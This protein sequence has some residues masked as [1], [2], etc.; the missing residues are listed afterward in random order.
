MKHV[1]TI[2][3]GKFNT[4]G[5]PTIS[6]T[7]AQENVEPSIISGCQTSVSGH[8]AVIY[9]PVF[10][11]NLTYPSEQATIL[12]ARVPGGRI[13]ALVFAG[14]Q[15]ELVSVANRFLDTLCGSNRDWLLPQLFHYRKIG[16]VDKQQL[17]TR[18]CRLS[19]VPATAFNWRDNQFHIMSACM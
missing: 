17:L 6:F 8:L 16:I 9:A 4:D 10:V 12:I 19:H 15:D 2:F 18:H 5:T 13:G 14:V 1:A 11:L 7:P 3:P